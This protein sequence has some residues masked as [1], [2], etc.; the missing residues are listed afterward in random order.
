MRRDRIV[1]LHVRERFLV[2]LKSG[3]AIEGVLLD[4]DRTSM[5]FADCIVWRGDAKWKADGQLFVARLDIAYMQT[6]QVTP[7]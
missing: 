2:T 5:V 1:K 6:A 7:R 4:A 3:E